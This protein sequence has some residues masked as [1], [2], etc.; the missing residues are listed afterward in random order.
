MTDH[1]DRLPIL[2]LLARFD[3]L[4]SKVVRTGNYKRGDNL[5][6]SI[7]HIEE[8]VELDSSQKMTMEMINIMSDNF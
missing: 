8:R 2:E 5:T 7:A 4:E 6:G 3:T 1:L